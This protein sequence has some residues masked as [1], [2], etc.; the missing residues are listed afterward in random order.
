MPDSD[1][2]LPPRDEV[3]DECDFDEDDFDDDFDDDFEEE[4]EEELEELE[5]ADNGDFTIPPHRSA[6]DKGGAADE[7]S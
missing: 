6:E 1:E 5:A 7:A 2:Q 4:T 3:Y